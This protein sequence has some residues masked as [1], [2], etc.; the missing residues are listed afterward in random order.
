MSQQQDRRI[1]KTR[2]AVEDAVINLIN[3]MELEEITVGDITDEADIHRTTFYK[4]YRDKDDLVDQ[5][6]IRA[7]AELTDLCKFHIEHQGPIVPSEAPPSLVTVFELIEE[8]KDFYRHLFGPNAP[9]LFVERFRIGNEANAVEI[10]QHRSESIPAPD[11]PASLRARSAAVIIYAAVSWWIEN[12]LATPAR[13]MA[14]WTWQIMSASFFVFN[15]PE[16][17]ASRRDDP[18]ATA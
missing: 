5:L 2:R 14:D 13:A 16:S 9:A 3:R 18:A 6:L 15:A 8:R 11:V 7:A 1:R 12:G 10:F 17:A 4:H